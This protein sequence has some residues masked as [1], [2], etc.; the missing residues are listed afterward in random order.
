VIWLALYIAAMFCIALPVA[1]FARNEVAAAIFATWSIG[2]AAY[3]IGMPEPQTQTALYFLMFCLMC[4][5]ILCHLERWS[6]RCIASAMFFLPLFTICY[7]WSGDRSMDP[8]WPIYVLAWLQ[9]SF[10]VRPFAWF[11]SAR[12]WL[13]RAREVR[14]NHLSMVAQ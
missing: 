8:W 11:R 1:W 9:L 5:R 13:A 3:V 10:I 4:A 12:R 7:E 2:H 6:W 14:S